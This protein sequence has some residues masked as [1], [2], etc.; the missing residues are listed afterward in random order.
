MTSRIKLII[1]ES[2]YPGKLKYKKIEVKNYLKIN[3]DKELSVGF[4]AVSKRDDNKLEWCNT[5]ELVMNLFYEDIR[6]NLVENKDELLQKLY[7]DEI[8]LINIYNKLLEKENRNGKKLIDKDSNNIDIV[9]E[10]INHSNNRDKEIDILMI[11]NE[12]INIVTKYCCR[13]GF[14]NVTLYSIIHPAAFGRNFEN[15]IKCW[16]HFNYNDVKYS[17]SKNVIKAFRKNKV[18]AEN[19]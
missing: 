12:A 5:M 8:Y 6:E 2:P 10:F 15:R 4:I 18:E 13:K 9:G 14:S 7:N 11:G 16:E 3:N 19:N 17:S 1:G